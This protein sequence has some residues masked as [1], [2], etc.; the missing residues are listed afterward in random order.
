MF[1]GAEGS[2]D[3]EDD[4]FDA[5]DDHTEEFKVCLPPAQTHKSVFSAPPPQ[6]LPL[7]LIC[8]SVCHVQTNR[9]E[10]YMYPFEVHHLCN[11]TLGP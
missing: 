6:S 11:I 1:A 3:E 10:E 5:V 4:F 2:E 7:P 8:L 9:I